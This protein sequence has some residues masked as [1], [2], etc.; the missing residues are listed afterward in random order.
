MKKIYFFFTLALICISTSSFAKKMEDDEFHR[1]LKQNNE[2]GQ[3]YHNDLSV[4]IVT[5]DRQAIPNKICAIYKI[6]LEQAKIAKENKHLKNSHQAE[7]LATE[8]INNL[9]AILTPHQQPITK[10][11]QVTKSTNTD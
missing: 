10:Y 5:G 2:L 3:Q 9:E 8:N 4:A 6:S 7:T 11:C 1:Y